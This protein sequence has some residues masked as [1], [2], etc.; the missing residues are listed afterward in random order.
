[1][2]INQDSFWFHSLNI[3][4]TCIDGSWE[5]M[6]TWADIEILHWSPQSVSFSVLPDSSTAQNPSIM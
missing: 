1:M 6:E 2:D 4:V 3:D 5:N